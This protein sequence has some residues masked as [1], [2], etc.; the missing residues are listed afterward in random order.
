MIRGKEGIIGS[1]E[2]P[3]EVA[4]EEVEDTSKEDLDATAMESVLQNKETPEEAFK[5]VSVGR[6]N[7]VVN[8]LNLIGNMAGQPNYEYSEKDINRMLDYMQEAMD[9]CRQCY[10]EKGVKEFKW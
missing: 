9:K 2:K 10:Q 4:S 6:I 1:D 7:K 3:T 5:R 8:Y